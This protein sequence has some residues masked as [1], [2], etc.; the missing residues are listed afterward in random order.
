MNARA[1]IRLASGLDADRID[2]L[3]GEA[4][5]A[6]LGDEWNELFARAG[7]PAQLFQSHALLT[8]WAKSFPHEAADTI[9]IAA[10]SAGRLVCIVP[11]TL[12][13]RF[14]IRQ[15]R[16]MGAPI[17]Q[18]D[19]AIV[20]PMFSDAG[21]KTVWQAIVDLGA[22]LFD[23]RR[24]RAD[25][26]LQRIVPGGALVLDRSSAPVACLNQRVAKDGPG[27]A[28]SSRERSNVRRRMKRL[29][30]RG[31]LELVNLAPGPEAA[32]LAAQAIDIKQRALK[33]AGIISPAV[34]SS[35][36]ERFFVEAAANPTAGMLISA[37]RLNGEPIAIDL[38]FLSKTT[39]FG[40]VLATEPDFFRDGA[41][42]ILVH[43]VFASAHAAGARSFD[44]LAPADEYKLQHADGS[45][46]VESRV[47]AFSLKGRMFAQGWHRFAKPAARA[48]VKRLAR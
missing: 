22:D 44:L 4:A 45:T 38:S 32:A 8:I 6:A 20:D 26:A 37:I 29:S 35:G 11:F 47:H 28:Y 39:A 21:C 19:D 30:E 9:V 42:A 18:F 1:Q 12:T 16:I 36:F 27:P 25:S 46:A 40:H 34:R 3:R 48:I 5:F 24:M 17:A 13:A 33:A 31:E 10:R 7:K 41:A 43:Q 14:G 23:I 2:I 15:L